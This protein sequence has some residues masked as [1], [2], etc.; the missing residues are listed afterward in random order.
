MMTDLLERND[1][2]ALQK[3]V[4]QLRGASGGYGFE[5]I[6][7]PATRAEESI[8]AGK[9][10]ESIAAQIKSLIEVIRRID[11]YDESKSPVVAEEPAK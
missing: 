7:E 8:K 3:I 6:T 11:G 4:H 1:L 10:P 2:A 9:A 5:P